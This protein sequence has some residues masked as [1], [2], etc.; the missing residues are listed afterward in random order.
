MGVAGSR[1]A[2]AVARHAGMPV[3]LVGGIGRLLPARMWEALAARLDDAAM[4]WEADDDVVP[5]DLVRPARAVPPGRCPSPTALRR[6]DCPIAPE[7][8]KPAT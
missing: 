6:I 4:P 1:A 5:S 3:W 8:F 7:L 2:A